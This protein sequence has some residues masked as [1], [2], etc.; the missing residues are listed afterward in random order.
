VNLLIK[1]VNDGIDGLKSI[2]SGAASL[3]VGVLQSFQSLLNQ[4]LPNIPLLSAL[5]DWIS[6]GEAFT[7]LNV[8]S[9]LI[10]L[11][12]TIITKIVTGKPPS[13]GSDYAQ[14][15]ALLSPSKPV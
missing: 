10:A 15:Q 1:V 14:L 8:V 5:W 13:A 2:V 4:T 7:I 9:L 6:E 12:S 3:L 11:P